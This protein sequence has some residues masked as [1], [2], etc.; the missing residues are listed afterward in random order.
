MACET[1]E[2]RG[3]CKMK[4]VKC[5]GELKDG[6]KICELCGAEQPAGAGKCVKCGAELK[7]GDEFCAVCGTPQRKASSKR[8]RLRCVLH[9]IRGDLC[10]PIY[11][12]LERVWISD[13]SRPS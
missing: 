1:N 6:A 5:D 12:I 2:R 7:D 10:R 11:G 9:C 4:C 3:L 8:R 13:V